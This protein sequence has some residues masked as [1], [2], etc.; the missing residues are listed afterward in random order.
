M[1]KP[2]QLTLIP[3]SKRKEHGGSLAVNKRRSY[4]PL[5]IK[6]SHHVTL[7]SEFAVGGRCLLR[8]QKLLKHILHRSSRRF[9]VRVYQ[10]AIAGNHLHVLVRARSRLGLQ[11]FFRVFAGHT[12]QEILRRTGGAPKA[13]SKPKGCKKNQRTFWGF[14]IY[15]RVVSWGREFLIVSN[16]VIQ[17]RLEALGV[18]AYQPRRTAV[19]LAKYETG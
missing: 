7:K 12:A 6:H 8:H 18:I 14:L 13:E 17:N 19:K 2:K 1:K 15:S 4:R 11:N 16:Y 9:G 10:F 5:S 3:I